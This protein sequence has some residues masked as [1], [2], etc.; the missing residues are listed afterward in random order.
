MT[1]SLKRNIKSV[2]KFPFWQIH[3]SLA[4]FGRLRYFFFGRSLAGVMGRSPRSHYGSINSRRLRELN[5]KGKFKISY[6]IL[7][8]LTFLKTSSL[9]NSAG[10]SSSRFNWMGIMA[11][12][13][14]MAFNLSSN[15]L[16]I[17]SILNPPKLHISTTIV[18]V[19]CSKF[20]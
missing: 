16:F 19:N 11:L 12:G 7:K 8:F 13:G 15:W 6:F 10:S 4:P 1:N 20:G 17:S 5:F 3:V 2:Q 14:S 18:L 9:A